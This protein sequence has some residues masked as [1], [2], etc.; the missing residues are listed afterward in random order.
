MD[1]LLVEHSIVSRCLAEFV[2]TALFV[3]VGKDYSN[4][5]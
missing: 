1:S 4:L 2:A 3:F 5:G